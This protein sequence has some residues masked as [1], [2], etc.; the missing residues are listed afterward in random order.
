MLSLKDLLETEPSHDTGGA[1]GSQRLGEP[2]DI[3][4]IIHTSGTT[5]TPKSVML[6]HSAIP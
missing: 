4:A 3:A 6:R 5:G 1:A 2:R